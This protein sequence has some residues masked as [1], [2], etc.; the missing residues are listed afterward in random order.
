MPFVAIW[1][2]IV[3]SGLIEG[4]VKRNPVT[5]L[6]SATHRTVNLVYSNVVE[7]EEF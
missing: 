4:L 5:A 3:V 7:S 1:L 2:F 6:E